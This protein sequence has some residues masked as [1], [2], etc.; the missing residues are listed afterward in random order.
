M[1]INAHARI[2]LNY[3]TSLN[4]KVPSESI[5]IYEIFGSRPDNLITFIVI[6]NLLEIKNAFV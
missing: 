1:E 6:S 3:N 5:R 4:Y 2:L